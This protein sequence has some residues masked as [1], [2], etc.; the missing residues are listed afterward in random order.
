MRLPVRAVP[1]GEKDR[2]RRK[3][4]RKE[5]EKGPLLPFQSS[6][7][8]KALAHL[9]EFLI[10]FSILC[11]F[12]PSVYLSWKSDFCGRGLDK[13]EGGLVQTCT[14]IVLVLEHRTSTSTMTDLL[15]VYS[16]SRSSFH[17]ESFQQKL[18]ATRA[19][20]T[21]PGLA[22][23]RKRGSY[24][25]IKNSFCATEPGSQYSYSIIPHPQHLAASQPLC[26]GFDWWNGNFLELGPYPWDF[27]R[28]GEKKQKSR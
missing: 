7:A 1:V 25:L 28:E 24:Y 15:P 27:E 14:C 3:K 26:I 18:G 22:E 21:Q 8:G 17:A 5:S 13:G 2:S 11:F 19:D 10:F 12:L 6:V 9:G 16:M 4:K 23:S 20:G